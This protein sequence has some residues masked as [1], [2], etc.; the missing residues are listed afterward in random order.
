VFRPSTGSWYVRV[1]SAPV[2]YGTSG[3]VP[4]PG[5]Y[6][7]DG[8]TDIAVFRPSSGTWYVAGRAPHALRALAGM[9]RCRATSTA[10]APRALPCFRPQ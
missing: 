10:T 3:D 2:R 4:V 9:S 6:D 5:D 1:L 7:G 8:T